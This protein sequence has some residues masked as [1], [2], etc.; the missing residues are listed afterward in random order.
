M[1]RIIAF[2]LTI[3]MLSS[4]FSVG[5]FAADSDVDI[6]IEDDFSLGS[7]W[8]TTGAGAAVNNG[9]FVFAKRFSEYNNNFMGSMAKW[10]NATAEFDFTITG[11]GSKPEDSWFM[12][13]FGG[14]SFFTRL[15][16]VWSYIMKDVKETRLGDYK[17][18]IGKTYTA[19]VTAKGRGVMLELK[20]K[21]NGNFQT[22]GVV[23]KPQESFGE[24]GFTTFYPAEIDNIKIYK[25]ADSGVTKC[26]VISIIRGQNKTIE[27]NK[28]TG[29]YTYSSTNEKIAIVDESGEITGLANGFASIEV[30]DKSGKLV[31][32]VGVKVYTGIQ[33]L[34]FGSMDNRHDYYVGDVFSMGVNR[35]PSDAAL[36]VKWSVEGDALE[37]KTES[38]K[39]NTFVAVKEGVASIVIQDSM[40]AAQARYEINVLPESAKPVNKSDNVV[41]GITGDKHKIV[42]Q[43]GIHNT[44]P[45]IQDVD[46]FWSDFYQNDLRIGTLRNEQM[47]LAGGHDNYTPEKTLEFLNDSWNSYKVGNNLNIPVYTVLK[48]SKTRNDDYIMSQLEIISMQNKTEYPM[49]IELGNE[50]YA[51]AG[52]ENHP[53]VADYVE[54]A[55]GIKERI[56]DK[57]PN[58]KVFA[59]LLSAEM[60]TKIMS[61]TISEDDLEGDWAYTQADRAI[62]WNKAVIAA[63]EHF[64]GFTVH[65]YQSSENVSGIT[66]EDYIEDTFGYTQQQYYH[67]LNLHE[68]TGW[69]VPL[70]Y[71]EWGQLN[72]DVFWAGGYD[73]AAK[74]RH[75]RGKYAISAMG[76]M[77]MFL[78][79]VKSGIIEASHY[80]CSR[81]SQGFGILE[82]NLLKTC[83]YYVFKQLSDLLYL[84][85][86]DYYY[87]VQGI[88]SGYHTDRRPYYWQKDEQVIIED[89]AAW[90]FG[91]EQGIKKVVLANHTSAPQNVSLKGTQ[92]K[93]VWSYG[94]DVD[95]IAPEW[96]MNDSYVSWVSAVASLPNADELLP[97]PNNYD[98]AGFAD[99]IEIPPYTIM[100]IE[101]AGSPSVIDG[102]VGTKLSKISEYRLN[103][104]LVLKIGNN[105]AVNDLIKTPIDKDNAS[106]VPVVKD[107]RTLLPLRFV[108]ESFGCDVTFDNATSGITIKG[109]GIN[110]QMT[111]G[112]KEY[113]VNGE[114]KTL[115]VPAEAT[116]GRTLVP[117]RAL[118]EAIGKDVLW[119]S[120]GLIIVTNKDTAFLAYDEAS[121]VVDKDYLDETNAH[122]DEIILLFE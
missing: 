9:K 111:L 61:D 60:E 3:V 17:I 31:D 48:P 95:T 115:D 119:D 25:D 116:E 21:D 35:V 73:S 64:D 91:T 80:H 30:K 118:A 13:T 105:T 93:P 121:G 92:I 23:A 47:L 41:L 113:T 32:V 7:F 69:D 81:D 102:H 26:N 46:G 66:A 97:K 103:N 8:W 78:N 65:D 67:L 36:T 106:I 72:G 55:V 109:D 63:K 15:R 28:D 96:S 24:L 98:G 53:T 50:N 45:T 4:C 82:D 110:V 2:F 16:G 108:A 5:V 114:A 83:N 59:V 90:G 33:S 74:K 87:D 62:E 100:T 86:F 38:F 84:E 112:S 68:R 40:G 99:S 19:R 52:A 29:T 107:G 12:L 77:E 20:E 11:D 104:A 101:I 76:N 88:E 70:A 14:V 37:L 42:A 51:I 57:W 34:S 58:A 120:R 71:T 56:K 22:V 75:Q 39:D 10:S 1:K 49:Y 89:V 18:D 44:I 43:L 85:N 79:Q 94:G 117:L 54:W 27:L 122:M 6:I